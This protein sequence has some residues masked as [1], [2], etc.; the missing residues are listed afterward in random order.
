MKKKILYQKALLSVSKGNKILLFFL[1]IIF[2]IPSY[3]Q[4]N[5]IS[6]ERPE[7]AKLR[8]ASYNAYWGSIF[9]QDNGEAP[10]LAG[11]F[12]PQDRTS[13]FI[14]MND[15]LKPDIWALQEVLY[16]KI[17]R[18]TK[19]LQGHL[20]YFNKVTNENWNAAADVRGRVV[21][22]RYPITYTK[23]IGV[24]MFATLIDLPD[25]ISKQAFSKSFI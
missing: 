1:W 11:K 8:I 2:C 4:T 5:N 22:S 21:F 6:F 17:E 23:K 14:R 13:N 15:A 9:P 18:E 12:K 24:R 10:S 20:D 19:T 25:S 7:G 3:G 16:S